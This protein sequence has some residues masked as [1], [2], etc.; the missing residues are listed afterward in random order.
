MMGCMPKIGKRRRKKSRKWVTGAEGGGSIQ[1]TT[2]L[3]PRV[4]QV[5]SNCGA[6]TGG[7]SLKWVG[8]SSIECSYCDAILSVEFEKIG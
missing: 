1:S 6:K 3:M 5:C 4:P 8:P 7:S 2:L